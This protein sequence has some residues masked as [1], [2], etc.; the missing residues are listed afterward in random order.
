M[1]PMSEVKF[2]SCGLLIARYRSD[3]KP[4]VTEPHVMCQP[5]NM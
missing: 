1:K 2:A 5:R 3:E 4:K